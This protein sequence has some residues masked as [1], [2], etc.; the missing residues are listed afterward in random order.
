MVGVI[1]YPIHT[2]DFYVKNPSS[3]VK[4]CLVTAKYLSGRQKRVM[5][6]VLSIIS[7][8]YILL[9]ESFICELAGD[10]DEHIF[11]SKKGIDH[12]GVKM[13]PVAFEND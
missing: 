9:D 8:I 5:S 3:Y 11:L 1:V 12:F 10:F 4:S 7:M 13:C 6:L 2:R